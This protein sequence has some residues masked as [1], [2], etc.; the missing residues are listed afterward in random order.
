MI[1]DEDLR[2]MMRSV[3]RFDLRAFAL[4]PGDLADLYSL[5]EFIQRSVKLLDEDGFRF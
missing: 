2:G 1:Q 3:K 4:T 5:E